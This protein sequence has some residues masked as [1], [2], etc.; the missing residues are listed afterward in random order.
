MNDFLFFAPPFAAG[1][2]LGVF[3]FGGLHW[4][5]IKGVSSRRPA[6]WFLGSVALRMSVTLAGFYLVGG[7]DWERW[8]LCLL[9]FMMGRTAVMRRTRPRENPCA[10]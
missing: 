4:T 8:L 6:F 2:L 9:A 7:G 3:F 1:L 5:V 10:P